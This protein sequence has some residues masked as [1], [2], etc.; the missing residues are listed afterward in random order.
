MKEKKTP[1]EIEPQ[2]H[3]G[4]ELNG[5]RGLDSGNWGWGAGNDEWSRRAGN[6]SNLNI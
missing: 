3:R 2:R 4:T 5:V 1:E 6:E